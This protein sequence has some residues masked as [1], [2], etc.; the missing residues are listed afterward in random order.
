MDRNQKLRLNSISSIFYQVAVLI[1]GFVLPRLII[2]NYGSATNGL[3]SSI[4]QFLSVITFLDLGVGSVVQA[5]MYKPLAENNILLMNQILNS[6]RKYF[7]QIANVLVVYILLL[8]LIYPQFLASNLPHFSTAFLIFA[9]SISRFAQYYFGIVNE[10]LLNADQKSYIQY[11]SE[12]VVVILNLIVSIILIQFGFSIQVVK[13]FSGLIFLLRP[14]YL[15]FYVNKNYSID[16]SVYAK[17][18]PIKQ[19]WNGMA[20]HLAWTVQSNSDILVLS[21]FSS[22]ESVSIYSIYNLVVQGIRVLIQTVSNNFKSFFG[23]ILATESNRTINRYFDTLEWS[24]HTVVTGIYALTATLIVP[25]IKIYTAGVHDVDYNVPIFAV[26]LVI[27]QMFFSIRTPYQTVVFAAGHFK[28]TQMSS[29]IEMFLNIIISIIAVSNLGLIGVTLGSSIA[30]IYRLFYLVYYLSKNILHRT[31]KN[32]LK[33]ILVDSIGFIFILGIGT[34][35]LNFVIVE[36]IVHWIIA[37]IVI[38]LLG[39]FV[40]IF[41]NLIFYRKLTLSFL[42]KITK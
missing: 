16:T 11:L 35:V 28:Q 20:Q 5:A 37:G 25:F 36:N 24:I 32:F 6:A 23:N 7:R 1:S 15:L 12:V 10:L 33:Q 14:I 26:C 34:L 4:S 40:L 41:L 39:I 9:I 8:M 27:S 22:L 3:V 29:I 19:K 30:M 31:I 38:T 17:E 13:F 21:I 2:V 18:E 42:K